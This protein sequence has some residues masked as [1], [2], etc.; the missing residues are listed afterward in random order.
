M[1]VMVSRTIN[2]NNILLIQFSYYNIVHRQHMV[3][4]IYKGAG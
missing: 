1:E 4:Y 3:R 2:S